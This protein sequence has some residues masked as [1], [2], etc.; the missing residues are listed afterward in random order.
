MADYNRRFAKAP[1]H[2]FNAHRPLV[3]TDD[4]D[5]VFTWREPRRASNSQTLQ[6]DKML[7]LIEDSEH[8]RRAIGKYIEVWHYPD[9]LKE[10]P[11]N[12]VLLPYSIY[13]RLSEVDPVA[14][15][16]IKDWGMCLKSCA[17]S[18][19]N[20]ITIVHSRY[21]KVVNLPED[22]MLRA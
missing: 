7:Y 17:K 5:V 3:L 11:L 6:Y 1:K 19:E 10:L 21:L 15:V 9:G 2:D 12:D 18:R 20:V 16:I 22:V 4:L 14:I 8:S 13:D